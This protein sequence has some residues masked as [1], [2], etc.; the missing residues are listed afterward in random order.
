MLQSSNSPFCEK[1]GHTIRPN[2]E[3]H[4]SYTESLDILDVTR[5]PNVFL[6]LDKKYVTSFARR[7]H[8]MLQ[9]EFELLKWT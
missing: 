6:P 5:N 7:W 3:M 2:A 8:E 1:S 9:V 4:K